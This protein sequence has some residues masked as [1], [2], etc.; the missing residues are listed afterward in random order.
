[1]QDTPF[2]FRVNAFNAGGSGPWS[3]TVGVR[4]KLPT[5]KTVSTCEDL[6]NVNNDLEANYIQTADI[7]CSNIANFQ[8]IGR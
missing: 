2:E 5:N 3:D 8:V 7:D 1:M 6:Q 4:T